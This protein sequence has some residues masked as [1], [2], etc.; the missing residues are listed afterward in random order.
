[1]WVQK[2]MVPKHELPKSISL[3]AQGL[4]CGVGVCELEDHVG[5]NG[6][7]LNW[8]TKLRF[9]KKTP[10]ASFLDYLLENA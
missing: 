8:L 4:N 2:K 5:E 6:L 9:A 3:H 7:S 10:F 1:M